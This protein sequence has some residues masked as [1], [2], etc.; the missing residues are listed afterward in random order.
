MT[1]EQLLARKRLN[2]RIFM[3]VMGPIGLLM[4]FLAFRFETLALL[5][6]GIPFTTLALMAW[7]AKLG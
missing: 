3:F 1:P 4:V 7:R 2:R 6:I 5:V